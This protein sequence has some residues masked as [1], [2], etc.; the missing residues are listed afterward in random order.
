[1]RKGF[2]LTALVSLFLFAAMTVT[3]LAADNLTAA[4]K[5]FIK[6]AASG[7][8]MEVD[9]GKVAQEKGSSQDVKDFG[10]RMQTDHQAAIDELKGIAA[11]YNVQL[12]A[13][14]ERRHQLMVDRLSK[15]PGPQ[16]DKRYM[17]AM[18]ADHK[19][20]VAAFKKASGTVKNPELKGWVDKTLPTLE[21]HLQ[22][23]KDTAQKVGVQVK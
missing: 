4:E 2:A 18:V 21:L 14:L 8:Q 13:Q 9:L 11:K 15:V 20:D 1:M 23:S 22:L 17:R 10:K 19:K 6:K 5:T 16:F 3:A 7:G 12:P